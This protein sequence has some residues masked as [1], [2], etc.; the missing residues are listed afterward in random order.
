MALASDLFAQWLPPA[1]ADAPLLRSLVGAA[2]HDRSLTTVEALRARGGLHLRELQRWFRDAV[3]VSPKWVIQRYRLHEA[4]L[5]LEQGQATV[6]QL[7]A[8][9]GYADQAH[10]A[11][12]FRRVV[13]VAPSAYAASRGG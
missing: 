4:L 6:A 3:G 1:P 7:A 5:A 2:M 9:L 12:D 8:D 11:R 13:G 10:F